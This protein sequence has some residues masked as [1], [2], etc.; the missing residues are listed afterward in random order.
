MRGWLFRL[1]LVARRRAGS[2]LLLMPVV[3]L[4]SEEI[5]SLTRSVTARVN[6]HWRLT[7]QGRTEQEQKYGLFLETLRDKLRA[8]QRK[9]NK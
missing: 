6:D 1:F 7:A 3:E 8:A 9:A 4:T 5:D 2:K